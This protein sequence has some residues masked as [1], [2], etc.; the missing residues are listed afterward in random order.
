MHF[1]NC[2]HRC[3]KLRYKCFSSCLFRAHSDSVSDVAVE[4]AIFALAVLQKHLEE[5]VEVDGHRGGTLVESLRQAANHH[6]FVT[7]RVIVAHI[8]DQPGSKPLQV[9]H[10]RVCQA[11]SQRD[12][13]VG[14][15]AK[16]E[17]IVV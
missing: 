12:N 15:I 2:L 16:D 13:Q 6:D 9:R 3:L 11:F 5:V 4:R 10:E 14:Y 1:L 17:L 7:S 8:L